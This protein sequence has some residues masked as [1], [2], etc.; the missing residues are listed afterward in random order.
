MVER[1]TANSIIREK[2]KGEDGDVEPPPTAHNSESGWELVR[3]GT[4]DHIAVWKYRARLIQRVRD[5]TGCARFV[6][7][8]SFFADHD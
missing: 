1:G 8:H 5:G 2:H 3:F 4:V 6:V 7:D